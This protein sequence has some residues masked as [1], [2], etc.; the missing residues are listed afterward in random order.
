M[1]AS[2]LLLLLALLTGCDTTQQSTTTTAN[3]TPTPKQPANSIPKQT[4]T[5]I[6][7]NTSDLLYTGGLG[8]AGVQGFCKRIGT[9]VTQKFGELGINAVSNEPPTPDQAKITVTLS[10]LESKTGVGYEFF[11][12]FHGAQKMRARYSAQLDSPTGV[13]LATWKHEVEEES[14]D[15][16]TDHMASDI[17]KYLKKGF[18]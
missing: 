9:Q 16:L 14:V 11:G 1:R 10:T 17:V 3:P 15:K 5:G 13:T 7:F 8:E 2:S 12:G 4:P 18:K 6:V